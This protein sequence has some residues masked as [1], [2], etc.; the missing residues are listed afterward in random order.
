MKLYI[1]YMV[2]LRC[3]ML[4]R[5]ELKNIGI[6][7]VEIE[8]GVVDFL[9][10]ISNQDKEKFAASLLR[11]GLE[12]MDDKKS[13]LIEKIK[14]L[15]IESIHYSE[16]IPKTNISCLIEEKI[17]LE[18]KYLSSLFS[19]VKGMTIEQFVIHHKVERVKE[20]LLYNELS[21]KEIS[22]LMH[23]NSVSHLSTQFKKLTGLTPSYFKELR[24]HKKR[25][26]LEKI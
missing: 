15:I 6:N 2:S 22:Y 10:K 18:Y 25:I 14:N 3:K 4:V 16:E 24:Q 26:E 23:Y 5:E 7:K 8:L 19:E 21:I 9:E 13:K 12:L 17:G 20:L 11:S 1:K